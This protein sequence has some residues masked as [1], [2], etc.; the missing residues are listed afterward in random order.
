MGKNIII[1][2]KIIILF[3]LKC[4]SNILSMALATLQINLKFQTKLKYFER[5][6]EK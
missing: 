4:V 5:V 3:L 6:R 1:I 2:I